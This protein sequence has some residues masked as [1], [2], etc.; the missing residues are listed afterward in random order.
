MTAGVTTYSGISSLLNPT[1]ERSLK[2]LRDQNLLVPTVRVFRDMMGLT[3]RKINEY[4]TLDLTTVGET[5]DLV[6]QVFDPA[7]LSSLTPTMKGAQVFISDARVASEQYDSI[8]QDSAD[9]FG[10]KFSQYVDQQIASNFSSLTGGTVGSGGGTISWSNI[11]AARAKLGQRNAPAPYYCVLGQGQ[12]YHLINTAL[13]S[14]AV[15]DNAPQFRDRLINNYFISSL[16]GG[17]TF[18]ITNNIT[19]AAGGTAYGAMYSPSA[20]AYDERRGFRI[21]AERDESKGTGGTELNASLW[22][23]HGTW[24]P[25]T[26]VTIVG[27]DVV[28]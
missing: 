2:A 25:I 11:L 26:G 15:V 20:I 24:R 19:G 9:E 7:A 3:L 23:A 12:W 28:A 10:A 22:F 21:A 4:G 6:P 27:T 18:V 14:A 1:Y 17:V 8:I 5:D 16:V 13:N